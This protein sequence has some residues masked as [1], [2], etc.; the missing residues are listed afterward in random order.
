[1]NKLEELEKFIKEKK[2]LKLN[3]SKMTGSLAAYEA[4]LSL[5]E[6]YKKLQTLENTEELE[7]TEKKWKIKLL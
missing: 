1:M 3:V 6:V 5:E 7:R 4:Y 2:E